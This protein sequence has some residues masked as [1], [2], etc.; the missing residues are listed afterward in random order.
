VTRTKQLIRRPRTT[1]A[2]LTLALL[3]I[4]VSVGSGADFTAQSANPSNTF[5]AGS[6]TMDNSKRN[7]AIFSPSNMKPGAPPQ[8]GTVDIENTGSLTGAF[9]LTRDQLASTDSGTPSAAAFAAKVNLTVLDCGRFAGAAAPG[10]GDGDDEAVFGHATLADM[11]APVA[12]GD[13]APG[14]RHRYQFAAALDASAGNEYAG[15][16]ASARFV[17]DAVQKP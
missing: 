10:C 17:W 13:F 4:G 16:G 3:A 9:T 5:A 7:A 15:D 1:L 8:T 12:L 2:A 11:S 14:E 6:L